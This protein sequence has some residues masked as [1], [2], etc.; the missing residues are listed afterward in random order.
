MITNNLEEHQNK[1]LMEKQG[2]QHTATSFV[3]KNPQCLK[4]QCWPENTMPLVSISCTTYNH[5]NYIGKSIESFLIQK[6]TFPV[7][8]LIHDDASTDGTAEIVNEYQER[9]PLLIQTTLQKE[10]QYNKGKLVNKFNLT[11]ARGKYIALCHGDD[12]WTDDGKLQKQVSLMM[13]HDA[14]IS[15]H[16][17]EEIDVHGNYWARK[18][19]CTVA[20]ATHFDSHELIKQHGTMLPF[21]S[22]MIT[23]KARDDILTHMPPVMFHTGIQLLGAHRNGLIVLPDAMS[24]YRVGVPGSTTNLLLKNKDQVLTTTLSRVR[25]IK[26]LRNLYSQ[27][28]KIAFDKLLAMQFFS[29]PTARPCKSH[30]IIIK[31]ILKNEP[32]TRKVVICLVVIH[33]IIKSLPNRI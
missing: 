26:Y 1:D 11:K 27:S 3:L 18:A 16:A 12:Y 33:A 20:H 23:D 5:L 10:N 4:D 29:I 6:T 24:A 13:Q 14:D 2:Q 30:L 15:G 25:S 31:A 8:I 32:L 21:G 17:A 9:Y 7:E 28:Y 22:I 19:G